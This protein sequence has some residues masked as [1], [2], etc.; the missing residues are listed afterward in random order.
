[1]GLVGL[2]EQLVARVDD[3]AKCPS[4]TWVGQVPDIKLRYG[5]P[6]REWRCYK[7]EPWTCEVFG[8]GC[9]GV[10]P[11]APPA[12]KSPDELRNPSGYT[13]DQ[14]SQKWKEEQD[15]NIREWLDA[16]SG[17]GTFWSGVNDI[18]DAAKEPLI[19][20]GL[21]LAIAA[22]VAVFLLVKFKS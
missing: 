19:Y 20:T 8:W 13:P 7:G 12:P 17:I 22:G 4:G 3:P 9:K 15:K 21:G 10:I 5:I 14:M 18:A 6:V 2:G 16:T 11:V 1:M